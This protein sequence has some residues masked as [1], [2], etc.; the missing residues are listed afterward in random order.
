MTNHDMIANAVR[1]YRG[2][3]LSTSDIRKI[4]VGAFPEFNLGSL[5]PND[6]AT[7][8]K[9]CCSCAGTKSRIFDLVELGKYRI[10]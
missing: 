5:L 3:T 4:V 6:H 2:K 8:N 10:R 9:S 1:N 7:G